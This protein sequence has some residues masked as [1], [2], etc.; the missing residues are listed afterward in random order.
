MTIY[1]FSHFEL[2]QN[3]QT[4]FCLKVFSKT[5]QYTVGKWARRT[6]PVNCDRAVTPHNTPYRVTFH[7]SVQTYYMDGVA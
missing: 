1:L 2:L 3:S 4:I 7:R 5:H 6:I